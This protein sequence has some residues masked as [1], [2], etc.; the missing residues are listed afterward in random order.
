MRHIWVTPST[1]M[2]KQNGVRHWRSGNLRQIRGRKRWHREALRSCIGVRR[3]PMFSIW[4]LPI[5]RINKRQNSRSDQMS[6]SRESMKKE[7]PAQLA[8][9]LQIGDLVVCRLGYGA[10]RITGDGVWGPPK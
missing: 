3:T 8:G 7:K 10:M 9:E 1:M 4:T 6:V 2:S 5:A